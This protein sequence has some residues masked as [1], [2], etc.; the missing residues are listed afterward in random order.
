MPGANTGRHRTKLT[1]G[2]ECNAQLYQSC[3]GGKK[4]VYPWEHVF[5]TPQLRL[6]RNCDV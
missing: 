6:R 3:K 4:V 5:G 2:K 1:T